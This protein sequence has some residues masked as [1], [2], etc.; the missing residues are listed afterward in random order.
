MSGGEKKWAEPTPFSPPPAR[1]VRG[2]AGIC[3]NGVKG[4]PSCHPPLPDGILFFNSETAGRLIRRRR[5]LEVILIM[6]PVRSKTPVF[7]T[8]QNKLMFTRLR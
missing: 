3:M 8:F 6:G 1:E 5:F 4:N 7:L 2:A